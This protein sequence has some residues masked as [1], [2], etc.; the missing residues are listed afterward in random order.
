MLHGTWDGGNEERERGTLPLRVPER[1][2]LFIYNL[3]YKHI[4]YLFT[5]LE[6]K[7]ILV[8]K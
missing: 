2:I 3:Y 8:S 4:S 5:F 1:W 6:M 7:Y